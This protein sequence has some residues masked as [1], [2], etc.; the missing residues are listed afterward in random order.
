M[1]VT[2]Q[3]ALGHIKSQEDMGSVLSQTTAGGRGPYRA[4]FDQLL[5]KFRLKRRHLL[6]NSRLAEPE[7]SGGLSE[8]TAAHHRQQ[9]TQVPDLHVISIA[10]L[11]MQEYRLTF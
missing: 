5:A 9:G 1:T 7:L 3:L 6:R 2:G 4:A 10:Y 11:E 8:R